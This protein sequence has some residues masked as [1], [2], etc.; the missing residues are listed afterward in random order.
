MMT[1]YFKITLPKI[2]NVSFGIILHIWNQIRGTNGWVGGFY[3]ID[4][5][6]SQ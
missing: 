6:A 5:T 1:H 2:L 3:D 4:I